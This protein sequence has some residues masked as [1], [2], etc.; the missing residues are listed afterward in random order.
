VF[1]T[2]PNIRLIFCGLKVYRYVLDRHSKARKLHLNNIAV[3][4]LEED[5]V[6]TESVEK[7]VLTC[8][9]QDL[10]DYLMKLLLIAVFLREGV[11]IDGIISLQLG[12]F[13]S[14]GLGFSSLRYLICDVLPPSK[15]YPHSWPF[16]PT[17]LYHVRI[18]IWVGFDDG[19]CPRFVLLE[20][21]Q[22]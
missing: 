6:S 10:R 4:V 5:I 16:V 21:Q 20:L 22:T 2:I 12:R 18:N 11:P 8:W 7:R 19:V 3:N 14:C 1:D 15:Q 13:V 9:P 17:K